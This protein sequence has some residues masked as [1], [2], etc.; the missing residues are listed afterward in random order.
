[1]IGWDDLSKEEQTAL[2]RMNRGHYRELTEEMACR[3]KSLGLA[4]ERLDGAGISRAGR[5]LVI[6][7][8][9]EGRN[10]TSERAEQSL[11]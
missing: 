6:K 1:M 9:L 2:K 10:G 8:L 7:T 4:H 3:L 11:W 5:E